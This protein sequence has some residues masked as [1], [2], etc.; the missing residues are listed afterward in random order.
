MEETT[1]IEE[2]SDSHSSSVTTVGYRLLLH[3][4]R[5]CWIFLVSS[6][7]FAISLS[8]SSISA[9]RTLPPRTE[10]GPEVNEFSRF[11]LGVVR[12]RGVIENDGGCGHV[13][14][15][16]VALKIE[17]TRRPTDVCGHVR[18]TSQSI[19]G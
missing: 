15:V 3:D 10:G 12:L 5:T 2:A 1:Q 19:V 4:P 14:G 16:R 7:S 17:L 6:M 18:P 9:S 11:S 13:G 8:F